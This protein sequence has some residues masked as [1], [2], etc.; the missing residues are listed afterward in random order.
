ML[1]DPVRPSRKPPLRGEKSA[2]SKGKAKAAAPK[3]TRKPAPEPMDEDIEILDEPEDDQGGPAEVAEAINNANRHR[4]TNAVATRPG[5][6][7]DVSRLTEQ[8]C[9]VCF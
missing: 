5:K 1:V 7:V 3:A 4:R 2:K 9:R 6:H 8:L